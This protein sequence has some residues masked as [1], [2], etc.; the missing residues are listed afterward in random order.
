[1]EHDTNIV[2]SLLPVIQA[3]VLTSRDH[4][5]AQKQSHDWNHQQVNNKYHPSKT[6]WKR[7]S[8]NSNQQLF[9]T[10]EFM[11]VT[12]GKSN[13]SSP[14]VPFPS[15]PWQGL[16]VTHQSV[17]PICRCIV[18][19]QEERAVNGAMALTV[20][21]PSDPTVHHELLDESLRCRLA[22]R[23]RWSRCDCRG[24]PMSHAAATAAGVWVGDASIGSC[25]TLAATA[26]APPLFS[27]SPAP[28]LVPSPTPSPS[29]AV[30]GRTRTRTWPFPLPPGDDSPT[31]TAPSWLLPPTLPPPS[32][33]LFSNSSYVTSTSWLVSTSVPL[34]TPDASI[35]AVCTPSAAVCTPPAAVCTPPA[36]VCTPPA[37]VCTP[38]ATVC[39]PPAT[40]CT[41]PAVG[42]SSVSGG[43]KG[44]GST[45]SFLMRGWRGRRWRRVEKGVPRCHFTTTWT[46]HHTELVHCQYRR[47]QN[48]YLWVM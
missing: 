1:M 15:V 48:G 20:T 2:T 10:L 46:Q 17:P 16:K 21:S 11:K 36:A 25:L 28:S 8:Q 24:V 32:G 40:V 12:L 19:V 41:P 34:S 45:G 37:A 18:A 30:T 27:P 44:G 14:T 35:F 26:A 9:S 13:T 33:L 38:P 31:P 4:N 6:N 5:I 43:S 47:L 3:Q 42:S 7:N 22:T 23:F 39:T 29:P